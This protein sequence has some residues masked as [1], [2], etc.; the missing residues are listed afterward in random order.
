VP[1]PRRAPDGYPPAEPPP[2]P[3]REP[4]AVPPLPRR[5]PGGYSPAVPPPRPARRDL[6]PPP[7]LQPLPLPR[8]ARLA[9][10]DDGDEPARDMSALSALAGRH[11]V[12]LAALALIAV[13]L[14]VK[15]A[16]LSHFYFRQDD[17]DV[18][19]QT[20]RSGLTWKLLTYYHTGHLYP[21]VYLISWLLAR[22]ALYSWAA[23]A[24]VEL[25][26]IAGSSLAAWRLLR[27]LMG[28]RPALL[29]P[30]ALYVLSP[31]PF[32][33]YSWWIAGIE[34]IPLQIAIFMTLDCHV[35]YVWT[36][37][38]RHAA[39][40]AAWLAFGLFFF[41]KS[42][43]IPLLLFA[44]TAGFL[45][46]KRWLPRAAGAA[47]ARFWPAWVLYLVLL[48]VYAGIF[49][50]AAAG[51]TQPPGSPAGH[52]TATFGWD[53]LSRSFA[54][55]ILGG[56]WRWSVTPGQPEAAANAPGI[57]SVLA[58][59]V[60]LAV[61]VASV[62]VRPRAWRGWAILAGWLVF[63]D[64]LPVAVGRLAGFPGFAGVLAAQSRYVD[65]A[66]AVLAVVVALVF[67]PLA[68]E[69]YS[70]AAAPAR[71]REFF[72]SAIWRQ[73]AIALTVVTVAGSLWTVTRFTTQTASP[74]RAYIANAT[75]ALAQ[76]PAGTVIVDQQVPSSVMTPLF[77]RDSDASVVLGPLARP[78]S[79]VVWTA[80][81]AGNLGAVKMFGPDGRLDAAAISGVSAGPPASTPFADCLTPAAPALSVRLPVPAAGPAIRVLR[82]DYLASG[83]AAGE[84]IRVTY[85]GSTSTIPVTGK[86]NN[87]YMAVTGAAAELTL[88]GSPAA[89]TFC[90]EKAVAGTFVPLPSASAPRD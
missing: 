34:A 65:D 85:N 69:R 7:P 9:N 8:P 2:L 48:A 30:L 39:A 15:G 44:V 6:V 76:V 12:S 10:D 43:V 1:L 68:S 52:V 31:L 88:Q 53:L 33:A 17:F 50:A 29:I 74:S 37:R 75:A 5:V 55:G 84:R 62:A 71:R 41:E 51:T 80:R 54:P 59:L 27:T 19:D 26:L 63:D 13:S 25:V 60:V 32:Q 20:L 36:G 79:R 16:F 11:R 64:V 14:L 72:P 78:G 89:G 87:F 81:P 58:L 22:S 3:R 61:V 67:W 57:L 47:L 28:S 45:I 73:A 24:G 90:L 56:P 83:A 42:A 18:L 86:A 49:L 23:G 82:I 21:G 77:G 46:R 35:R 70:G 66:V 38:F 4:P 40:A